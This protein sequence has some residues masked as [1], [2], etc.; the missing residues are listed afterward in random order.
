MPRVPLIR[1]AVTADLAAISRLLGET[2][3]ATYDGIYGHD[4]ASDITG[5]WHSEQNLQRG[6]AQE[7]GTFLVA[8]SDGALEGTASALADTG[9]TKVDLLRLYVRPASQGQ[10]LGKALLL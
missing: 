3:H 7:C 6:L 10:G 2:W 8:E 5:R 9:G 1:P 4:R